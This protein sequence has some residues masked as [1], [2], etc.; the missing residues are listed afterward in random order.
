MKL[1][2]RS[3]KNASVDLASDF[4]AKKA[5][6][7]YGKLCSRLKQNYVYRVLFNKEEGGELLNPQS[8]PITHKV[9]TTNYDPVYES[10]SN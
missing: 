7:I 9:Y 8:P 3:V 1:G 4:D 10:Y 2:S 5:S 6:E